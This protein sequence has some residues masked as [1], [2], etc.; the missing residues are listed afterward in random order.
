MT[1]QKQPL[2][3]GN[4]SILN[5]QVGDS[6]HFLRERERLSRAKSKVF[7]C[8][9]LVKGCGLLMSLTAKRS[10]SPGLLTQTCAPS[11]VN[12]TGTLFP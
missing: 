3:A 8:Y 4:E 12:A 10:L 1:N 7:N 6:L 2:G 11:C 9:M 5:K